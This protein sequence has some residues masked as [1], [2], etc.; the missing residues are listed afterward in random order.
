MEGQGD[1]VSRSVMDI[2]RIIRLMR[3]VDQITKS[4]FPFKYWVTLTPPPLS[5]K[6][7]PSTPQ[8]MK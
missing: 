2:T 5:L 3:V 7:I 1:F 8:I 4:P 6:T